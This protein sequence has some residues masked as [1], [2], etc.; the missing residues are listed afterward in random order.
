MNQAPQDST[1]SRWPGFFT[2]VASDTASPVHTATGEIG[3]YTFRGEA[4]SATPELYRSVV[5]QHLRT[6][7]AYREVADGDTQGTVG[8][9]SSLM[10]LPARSA[11]IEEPVQPSVVVERNEAAIALLES[12]LAVPDTGEDD[13]QLRRFIEGIE[14]DRLSERKLYP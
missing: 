11:C 3:R 13:E 7:Q 1:T 2:S 12:W 8:D 5:I 10:V 4:S 6:Y 14:E 9:M